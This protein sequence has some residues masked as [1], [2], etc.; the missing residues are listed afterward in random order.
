MEKASLMRNYTL[1]D[2]RYDYGALEPHLSGKV[3]ELHHDKHHRAYVAGANQAMEQ[4][5][6]ARQQEEFAATASLEHALAFNL[7]GHVLHSLFWQNLSPDGGGLP[8]DDLADAL[9]RDFGSFKG[10]KQQMI[11]AA[12]SIYGSGWAS[13]VWDPIGGRLA[14]LQIKDHQS[15]TVQSSVPL[16]VLDAWE[17]A[18]YLQ[19]HNE[20]GRYFEAIWN[21]WNWQDIAMRLTRVRGLDVSLENTAAS[22]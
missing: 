18:Y 16:M 3:M 17:H 15:T 14:V 12:S 21:L 9:T 2:L 6:L 13:L 8:E 20:K 10:F 7:S 1:P 19:Y 5:L 4:L 22:P 11:H